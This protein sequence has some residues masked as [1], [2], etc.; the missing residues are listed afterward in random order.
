MKKLLLVLVTICLVGC[1]SNEDV[2]ENFINLKIDDIHNI[3]KGNYSL[4][5]IKVIIY[6]NESDYLNEVNPFYKGNF[7][8]TG[9]F[10]ISK[11]VIYQEY[12]IDVFTEDNQ[13]SNFGGNH[14]FYPNTSATFHEIIQPTKG[15]RIFLGE[16][17]FS[18]YNQNH[19]G[20][21][22]HDRTER[23]KL[24]IN[25]DLSVISSETYNNIDF[26][27]QYKITNLHDG[28]IGLEHISTTPSDMNLYPYYSSAPSSVTVNED[29][30]HM[31]YRSDLK[32][33][34]F[35]D[36]ADENVYYA[37]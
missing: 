36:Y 29:A 6:L 35:Y 20:H 5:D 30:I 17:S 19:Y 37:K 24:E 28:Q 16:W 7:N 14:T 25:K 10:S 11:N 15:R 2:T 9:E 1:S 34:D 3:V 22:T 32:M 8:S 33:I 21:T 23:K 4:N 13:I 12:F 26:T 27:V 31:N 18:S